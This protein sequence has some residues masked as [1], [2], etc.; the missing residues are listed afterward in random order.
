MQAPH[1]IGKYTAAFLLA[2][3]ILGNTPRL[4]LHDAFARHTDCRANS[5]DTAGKAITA[6]KPH[7]QCNDVVIESPFTPVASLHCSTPVTVFVKIQPAFSVHAVTVSPGQVL[8]RG[9]PT[10]A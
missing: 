6:Q 7:C 3:F 9:P 10:T 2:L 4:W 1:T 8:L 5:A